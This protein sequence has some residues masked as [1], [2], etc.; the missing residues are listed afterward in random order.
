MLKANGTALTFE[1]LMKLAEKKAVSFL[2]VIT[3]NN[4]SRNWEPQS[5]IPCNSIPPPNSPVNG[6]CG[7]PSAVGPPP[8]SGSAPGKYQ[9]RCRT[10]DAHGI[11][12]PMPRP[13]P[14]SGRN[15]IQCLKI[16]VEA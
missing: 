4:L 15:A 12:Q 1:A 2:K 6:R 16:T 5:C 8:P 7:T 10:I 9:L 3:C 14:K 13:F 11:P